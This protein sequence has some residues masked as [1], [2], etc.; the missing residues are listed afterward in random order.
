MYRTYCQESYCSVKFSKTIISYAHGPI[1]R[2]DV[3]VS[4]KWTKVVKL[5]DT[6]ERPFVI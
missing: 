4:H 5:W 1:E 6:S 3:I 2:N